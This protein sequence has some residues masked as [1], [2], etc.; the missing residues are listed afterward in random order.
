MFIFFRNNVKQKISMVNDVDELVFHGKN[1]IERCT[2]YVL[3]KN[4]NSF[5]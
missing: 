1:F 3:E 5:F 4:I 2:K